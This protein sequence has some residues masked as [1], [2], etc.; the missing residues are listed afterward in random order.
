M[1]RSQKLGTAVRKTVQ[2]NS[3]TTYREAILDAVARL[4]V[5]HGSGS[6]KMSDI[7]SEAGV[8]VGSL[9]HYFDSKEAVIVALLERE[10]GIYCAE[11]Q[12]ARTAEDPLE[13]IRQAVA[14]TARFID[15]RGPLFAVFTSSHL[16]SDARFKCVAKEAR[17]AKQEWV[18]RL[19]IADLSAAAA[20]GSLRRDILPEEL[21]AALEGILHSAIQRWVAD[22]RTRPLPN[23]TDAILDLFLNGATPQ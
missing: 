6:L 9:Y 16:E 3:R 19:L 14:C 21:A 15:A 10:D 22:G 5:E 8:S 11:I 2:E 23:W 4:L 1:A 18:H 13:R 17:G 12:Q 7:A 20:A